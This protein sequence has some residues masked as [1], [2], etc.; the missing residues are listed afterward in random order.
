MQVQA[1]FTPTSEVR[2][3]QQPTAHNNTATRAHL[4]LPACPPAWPH[5]AHHWLPACL[6]PRRSPTSCR[7]ARL[8][9]LTPIAGPQLLPLQPPLALPLTWPQ[10]L[11]LLPPPLGSPLHAQPVG[12]NSTAPRVTQ[13]QHSSYNLQRHLLQPQ[14]LR[15]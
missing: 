1:A 13:K 10:L 4:L 12:C 6:A 5:A 15:P 8:P 7:L 11:P 9:G 3:Q 2:P 14:Q